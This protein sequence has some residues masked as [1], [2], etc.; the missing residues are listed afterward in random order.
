MK[1][2]T[3]NICG[4]DLHMYEGRTNM[5]SDRVLRHGVVLEVGSDVE[6]IKVGDRTRLPFNASCGFARTA[7]EV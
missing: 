5:E 7:R 2:T 1:I 4:S 3:T 6:R